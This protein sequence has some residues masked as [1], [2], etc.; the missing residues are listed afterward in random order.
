MESACP[1]TLEPVSPRIDSEEPEPD[2]S[3]TSTFYTPR[4]SPQPQPQPCLK[5]P[6]PE[7][8]PELIA[9]R[10]D[11]KFFEKVIGGIQIV[12]DKN[13]H[14]FP[15]YDNLMKLAGEGREYTTCGLC[16]LMPGGWATES[17]VLYGYEETGCYPSS[18]ELL[19]I[20]CLGIPLRGKILMKNGGVY[21]ADIKYEMS[22][23]N[24]VE[25]DKYISMYIRKRDESRALLRNKA[26]TRLVETVYERDTHGRILNG[27]TTREWNTPSTI[28]ITEGDHSYR[29]GI[30]HL[31]EP[32]QDV[33]WMP[34]KGKKGKFKLCDDYDCCMSSH[35][36]LKICQLH[37]D[38]DGCFSWHSKKPIYTLEDEKK[39]NYNL[40]FQC[41][42]K[43][44]PEECRIMGEYKY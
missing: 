30:F 17:G 4:A 14:F 1:L 2:A 36:V 10:A 38:V 42:M 23:L 18:E 24:E 20:E 3:P 22:E 12:N 40:C 5:S 44:V 7:Q 16:T 28:E 8:E 43:Y 13:K 15:N 26:F 9:P 27:G 41:I 31:Y 11:K 6:I 21:N 25:G 32:K 33:T 37:G 19:A 39:G 35:V 34:K 29:C